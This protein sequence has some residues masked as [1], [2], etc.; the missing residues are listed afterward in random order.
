MKDKF[1]R[2]HITKILQGGV[3]YA[4]FDEIVADF[5]GK[6]INTIFPKGTYSAWDLLEHIR[7][8]QIDILEF[9]RNP[10]YVEPEWPKD[11]WPDV[12]KKAT[13]KD[14]QN[15]ITNYKKELQDLISLLNDPKIDLSAKVPNGSS[16]TYLREFLLVADHTSYHLGEFSIMRQTM[17]TWG[18]K[19]KK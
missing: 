7:R 5:P 6:E 16:Q 11:Y 10:K 15:T 1:F 18:K 17:N 12:K 8:T 19:S 3:V 4:P 2:E 14:W 13:I 9:M